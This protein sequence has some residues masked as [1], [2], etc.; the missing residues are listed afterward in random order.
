MHASEVRPPTTLPP[1]A[2]DITPRIFSVRGQ[3]VIL[4]SHL[5]EL[6][7][8]PHKALMQ[9]VRRNPTRFP[10]DF[11]FQ[12]TRQ[13]LTNL[14]SQIVTSSSGGYGGLRKLPSAFTEHGALMVANVL[15][16]RRA[17]QVSVEVVRAFVQLRRFALSNRE[18]ARKVCEL[19]QRYDGQFHHVFEALRA[20]LASPEPDH[21]RKI[22]FN[23]ND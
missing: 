16:S 9:A 11:A 12:I 22:G 3:K 23:R 6:Y 7:G 8:V 15:K 20:L 4:S 13:E 5:A 2:I 19:E 10:I 1:I 17:A 18:L 14:K 21:R